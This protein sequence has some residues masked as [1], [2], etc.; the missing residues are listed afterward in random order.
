MP[1]VHIHCYTDESG[2]VHY[3]KK[4]SRE[5]LDICHRNTFNSTCKLLEIYGQSYYTEPQLIDVLLTQLFLGA[6]CGKHSRE[7]FKKRKR[8]NTLDLT[9]QRLGVPVELHIQRLQAKLSTIKETYGKTYD[10]CCYVRG[11]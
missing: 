11:A 9:F 7:G 6:G 4:A 8:T 3:S 1:I 5:A 2:V 10:L